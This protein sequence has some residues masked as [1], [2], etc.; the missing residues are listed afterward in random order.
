MYT[1]SIF[2]FYKSQTKNCP[3]LIS[4]LRIY[5]KRTKDFYNLIIDIIS[6]YK[7]M[8]NIYGIELSEDDEYRLSLGYK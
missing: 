4:S 7:T 2:M 1:N 3:F 5:K 8:A 6:G